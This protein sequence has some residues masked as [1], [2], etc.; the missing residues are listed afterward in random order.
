MLQSIV[1][2]SDDN[3]RL[4]CRSQYMLC[5][6][7]EQA[8][9]PCPMPFHI[10]IGFIGH[11]RNHHD[12]HHHGLF[13]DCLHHSFVLWHHRRQQLNDNFRYDETPR[14]GSAWLINGMSLCRLLSFSLAQTQNLFPK[15][16]DYQ[17]QMVSATRQNT[18]SACVIRY[19]V[20]GVESSGSW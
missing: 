7:E 5:D 6:C 17:R 8:Y 20:A 3:S 11:H 19:R 15:F 2:R 1:A 4:H 16:I 9:A 12:H 18:R 14:A 13:T 10:N